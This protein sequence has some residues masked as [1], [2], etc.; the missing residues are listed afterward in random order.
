MTYNQFHYNDQ[1]P[2][3]VELIL[4]IVKGHWS[5]VLNINNI[6]NSIYITAN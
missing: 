5:L 6:N 1:L 4:E 3:I 2:Y